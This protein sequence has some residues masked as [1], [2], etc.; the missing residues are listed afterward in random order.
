VADLDV[1]KPASGD[2]AAQRFDR[3]AE[4]GSCFALR[5]Q[6]VGGRA[7]RLALA[8]LGQQLPIDF[9]TPAL[10]ELRCRL[11]ARIVRA[12]MRGWST[13]MRQTS[14]TAASLANLI[15]YQCCR[16]VRRSMRCQ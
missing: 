1:P 11:V 5:V 13:H 6:L 9:T 14:S 10:F 12:A 3:A 7:V 16:K 8:P 15:Q 4:L 2:V